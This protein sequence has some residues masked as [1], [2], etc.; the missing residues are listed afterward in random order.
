M[1]LKHIYLSTNTWCFR[2]KKDKGVDFIFNWRSKGVYSSKPK[3]L[4]AAFLNSI[5]LC[6]YR[7][8]IKFDKEPL[9]LKQINYLTKTVN[10]YIVYNL[11]AWPRYWKF[12]G[13]LFGITNIVKK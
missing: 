8:G 11:D 9:I 4:Y 3:P 7:I 13:C 2:I 12:K 5:K 6:E 1:Y 10:V